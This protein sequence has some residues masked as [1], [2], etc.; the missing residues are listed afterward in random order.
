[1]KMYCR[2]TCVT[3]R[4]K[5]NHPTTVNLTANKDEVENQFKSCKADDRGLMS[6]L[7]INMGQDGLEGLTMPQRCT[8]TN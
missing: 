5:S 6:M 3:Q 4:R 7:V 2:S 8:L 1:M